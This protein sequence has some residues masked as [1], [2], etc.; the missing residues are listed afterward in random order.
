MNRPTKF[1]CMLT[2]IPR[3]PPIAA[4]TKENQWSWIWPLSAS[5]T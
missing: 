3:E 5:D 1:F 2:V 4:P